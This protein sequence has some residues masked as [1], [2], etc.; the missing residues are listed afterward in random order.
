MHQGVVMFAVGCGEVEMPCRMADGSERVGEVMSRSGAL[1]G[2]GS[3]VCFC[4]GTCEVWV[5]CGSRAGSAGFGVHVGLVWRLGRA[6][7]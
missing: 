6:I 7:S 5:P 1:L 4:A 2:V 3:P